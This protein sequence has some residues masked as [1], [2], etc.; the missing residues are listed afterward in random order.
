MLGKSSILGLGVLYN[1]TA[2]SII[3][4]CWRLTHMWKTLAWP[5]Y[6]GQ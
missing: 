2:H 5:H 3:C 6:L 1:N 4:E